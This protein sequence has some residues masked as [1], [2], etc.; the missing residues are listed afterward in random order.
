MYLREKRIKLLKLKNVMFTVLG[1]F[2]VAVSA[3]VMLSLISYY[4]DSLETVLEAK[5]TPD[6][7]A[8]TIIGLILLLTAGI[9]RRLIGDAN[10][11]MGVIH[12]K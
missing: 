8:A 1:I 11:I 12:K 4:H 10:F 5:A 2:F 9:S 6:S 3:F 7:I